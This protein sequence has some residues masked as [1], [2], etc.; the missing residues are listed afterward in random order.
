LIVTI[1]GAKD[2]VNQAISYLSNN[3]V[4][5]EVVKYDK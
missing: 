2:N 5:V 4:I 1:D 3:N